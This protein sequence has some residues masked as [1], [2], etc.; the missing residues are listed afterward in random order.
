MF[1]NTYAA[2]VPVYK[3]GE[4]TTT[5]EE[6]EKKTHGTYRTFDEANTAL[7]ISYFQEIMSILVCFR[8]CICTILRSFRR[9][10]ANC[11]RLFDG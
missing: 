7:L 6:K 2:S 5:S 11:L 4:E 10:T 9:L 1:L 3:K 8:Y